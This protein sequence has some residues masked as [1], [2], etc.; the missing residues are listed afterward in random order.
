MFASHLANLQRV[1]EA[2]VGAGVEVEVAHLRT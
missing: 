2:E 1:V